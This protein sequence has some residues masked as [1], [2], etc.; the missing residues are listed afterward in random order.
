LNRHHEQGVVRLIRCTVYALFLSGCWRLD[1][2]APFL[3]M[4]A[5]ALVIAGSR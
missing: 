3:G 1:L 5:E 4:R 2:C